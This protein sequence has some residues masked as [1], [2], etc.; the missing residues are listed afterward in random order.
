MDFQSIIKSGS[1]TFFFVPP[2]L[3]GGLCFKLTNHEPGNSTDKSSRLGG[4]GGGHPR[5]GSAV[6]YVGYSSIEYS[7]SKVE[8]ES[9]GGFEVFKSL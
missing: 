5:R 7:N 8:N 1:K 2:P 6:F 4:C 9:E 3:M